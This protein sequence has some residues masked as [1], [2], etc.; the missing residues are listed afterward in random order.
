MNKGALRLMVAIV[1]APVLCLLILLVGKAIGLTDELTLKLIA[2][3]L[4]IAL[5][6]LVLGSYHHKECLYFRF[7]SSNDSERAAITSA[8]SPILFHI[9][10]TSLRVIFCQ[11]STH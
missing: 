4:P 5:L 8:G 6:A 3:V 9:L 2:S 7:H 11:R 10:Q 1:C